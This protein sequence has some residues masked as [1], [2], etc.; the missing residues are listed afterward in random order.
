MSTDQRTGA[1][2]NIGGNGGRFEPL[3]Y[4]E[5]WKDESWFTLAYPES[6]RDTKPLFG[7]GLAQ[8]TTSDRQH[9]WYMTES[10]DLEY[11][12]ILGSLPLSPVLEFEI[13]FPA[14]LVFEYQPPLSD[15][16]QDTR[17]AFATDTDAWD[18]TG[19]HLRHRPENIVGS[20]ALYW[21]KSNNQ[22]QTGKVGHI[23]RPLLIDALGR[24]VYAKLSID[25]ER[26]KLRITCPERWLSRATFPVIV[27]PTIGYN[28]IGGSID[29][30]NDYI[31]TTKFTA[32]ANGTTAAG[33][34]YQGGFTNSGTVA[35]KGA[36]YA[37]AA[38]S[39]NGKSK[40]STSD[41]SITL[42]TTTSTFQSG[43]LT[44]PALVNG[45][46]YYLAEGGNTNAR[47]YYDTS[48]GTVHYDKW[49]P[50]TMPATYGTAD[51]SFLGRMSMY[52]DYTEDT[53]G[54]GRTTKNTQ[55]FYLGM[56]NGMNL[57]GNK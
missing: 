20:Y 33:T 38:A 52:V 36:I 17:V 6:R 54:G 3:V 29:D 48:T 18:A 26:K 32:P 5:K 37:N 8:L 1:R 25:V 12:I 50:G 53:G 40:V 49:T 30:T 31:V 27:D 13:D 45:T 47:Y 46:S 57:W 55:S 21:S 56:F 51:G 14:G 22:Y 11:E 41:A 43:A 19:K 42:T 39:P 15:E 16:R 7:G 4:S 34:M 35:A 24:K 23:H 9:N 44:P 10:G 2:V 28:V